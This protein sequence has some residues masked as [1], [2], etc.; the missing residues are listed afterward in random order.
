MI[1]T[2]SGVKVDVTIDVVAEIR[3]EA[4]AA[5]KVIVSVGTIT[6]LSFALSAP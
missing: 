4:L 3:V 1:G 5:V 6:V 2:L